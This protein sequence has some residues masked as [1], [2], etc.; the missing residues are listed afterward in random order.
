MKRLRFTRSKFVLLL[1]L[2]CLVVPISSLLP[3]VTATGTANGACAITPDQVD[4]QG[5]NVT[6]FGLSVT[7]LGLNVTQLGLN[8]TGFGL[9][10]TQFGLNVTQFGTPEQITADIIN[11]PLTPAW[12]TSQ[13]PTIAG[14]LGYNGTP[15]AV[16][17]VDDFSAPTAHGFDVRRVFDELYAAVDS[18]DD[19]LA[20]NSPNISLQNIDI[21]VEAIGFESTAIANAIRSAV[22][23][24]KLQGFKHF[25]INMSFGLLPCTS[26]IDVTLTDSGTGQQFHVTND[27]SYH[28]FEAARDQALHAK[29]KQVFPVLE[30]VAKNTN[31]TYTAYFGYEN[32]NSV[33]VTIPVGNDNRFLPHE[34]QDRGQ[35]SVFAPGR[36]QFVFKVDFDGK[37]IVWQLKGPDGKG[38]TATASSNP[39]MDC[40][41]RGITPPPNG[42][43]TLAPIGYGVTQFA[44]QALGVPQNF[45]DEYLHYLG[46][47]V[48][49]DPITGLQ[50]LLRR[51][52]EDSFADGQS[53]APGS[54]FAVIP[55]AA[56]GNFR[57]LFGGLPLQPAFF[58]ETIASGATLGDFGARWTLSHD[59]NLL[60]PGA[61][62]VFERDANGKI[63]RIGAGTSY[64]APFVSM[65]S[66]LWLTYDDACTFGNGLPP[67]V[68]G[69]RIKSA[70]T[71]VPQG[72]VSPLDCAKPAV[73]AD[74]SVSKDGPSAPVTIGGTVEYTISVTNHGP[75]V[76]EAVT[77]TDTLPASTSL[78]SIS[79]AGA[80]CEGITCS[81]GDMDAGQTITL[82]V[83]TTT[84]TTAGKITNHVSVSSST[85]DPN[86]AN[87]ADSA[88]AEIKAPV[89]V[90][91]VL[92]CVSDQ[93][94]GQY[95]AHF[96]Y[97]NPNS[98]PVTIP[99]G[100]K[101]R[102]SPS[103]QNRGQPT[104]FQPGRQVDA[105][106][107]KF[108]GGNLVWTLNG[109][110]ATASASLAVRCADASVIKSAP[111]KVRAGY[112]LVYTMQVTNTS[113]KP[114]A[115]VNN[116]VL[117]DPLPAGVTVT[118]LPSNCTLSDSNVLTCSI[119]TLAPGASVVLS[120]TV[121]PHAPTEALVN[122]V[123]VTSDEGVKG[124]PANNTCTVTTQ[125]ERSDSY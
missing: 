106:T 5:L 96:G 41:R 70:N 61:G 10:V 109:R 67:L 21:S 9:S 115:S 52:L 103:P 12:L 71:I 23:T 80:V 111:E 50:A 81:L 36:R 74:L 51:Y 63:L 17:I 123:T 49:D 35:P 26:T 99:V 47:Q 104:V 100:T 8:V 43:I 105:F 69:S 82:V 34:P 77:L 102:F 97:N 59:G 45:A 113:Q 75:A 57:H 37:N 68:N 108:N 83:K 60:A 33:S 27:F 95:V 119:G 90:S 64:A 73:I 29:T 110:T 3:S 122:T 62:Y 32:K 42:T 94:D 121:I 84:P 98:V 66:A 89:P 39:T 65:L 125:V 76:A 72:G 25:V 15:T 116:V 2:V 58:P 54:N 112:P 93:G 4:G 56:S 114:G 11:N 31:G 46:T 79:S 20:N 107:V 44:T 30:C 87:N 14:G 40:K 48:Q 92:E 117:T 91:P 28:D 55:V 6:G 118:A 101:N 38:R 120:V 78:I 1:I 22:D 53:S 7:Q 124:N 19:G 13:L 85:A 18:S 16:L 24:L 88:D 86:N